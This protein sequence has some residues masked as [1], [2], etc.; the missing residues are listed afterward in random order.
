M[1]MMMMMLLLLLW[2]D[3]AEEIKQE[4]AHVGQTVR[5]PCW[6]TVNYYVDWRRLD[7]LQS[8]HT[9]IYSNGHVWQ[10]FRSRFSVQVTET[11]D[12][13]DEYTLVIANV[14]LNDT[15]YYLCKEEAGIGPE[16]YFH[17]NITG[18]PNEFTL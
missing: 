6:T 16:H 10:D 9:Y 14:Q 11:T 2:Y 7:T 8:D 4:T 1:M 13:V 5:L 18:R 17:L 12:K 3:A 15:A